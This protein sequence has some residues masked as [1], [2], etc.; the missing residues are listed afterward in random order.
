MG[1]QVPR[2]TPTTAQPRRTAAGTSSVHLTRWLL[3]AGIA[4]P[5]FFVAVFTIAGWLTPGYSAM[6]EVISYLELGANGWIQHLN[7]M[8]SGLL[9]VLFGVGFA[10]AVR[11]WSGSGWRMAAA[12]A[13]ALSGAGLCMAGL[14]APD[15]PGTATA[16]ASVHGVLHTVSF[17]L[18][19]LPLGIACLVVG[20]R[21]ISTRGWRVHGGY[22][23]LAGLM[24]IVMALGNLF[25]TFVRS[26]AS[27]A[28]VSATSSQLSVGGLINRVLVVVTFAWYVVLAIRL[29]EQRRD[30]T[31]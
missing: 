22:S 6:R 20:M 4:G 27:N 19:F 7:F 25:S 8:V 21:V 16:A 23:L 18:V 29:L 13:I 30:I 14:F 10:R 17:T 15:P 3:A 28:F 26:N 2:L 24:A 5:V 9:L 11:S 12:V 1:T 31:A